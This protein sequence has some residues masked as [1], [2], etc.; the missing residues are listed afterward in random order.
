MWATSSESLSASNNG[1][2]AFGQSDSGS[3]GLTVFPA[4]LLGISN[5]LQTYKERTTHTWDV[6]ILGRGRA[7]CW[8]VQISQKEQMLLGWRAHGR[9]R[10][11]GGRNVR[12]SCRA[13]LRI[14]RWPLKVALCHNT[15]APT[16]PAA[17]KCHRPL[18]SAGQPAAAA[19][20]RHTPPLLLFSPPPVHKA[21]LHQSTTLQQISLHS[22]CASRCLARHKCTRAT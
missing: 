13:L 2:K 10:E 5:A 16:T 21:E 19:C 11:R 12:W 4:A 22:A 3:L 7:G 14:T 8:K 1:K 17:V 9:R 18:P 6:G 15:L 20:R